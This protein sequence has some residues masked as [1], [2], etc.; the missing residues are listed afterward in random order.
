MKKKNLYI[1]KQKGILIAFEGVSG[2]G[3]SEGVESLYRYLLSRGYKTK[4]I[5]WN[6]NKVIRRIV[7]KIHSMKLLTSWLYSIFQWISFLLDYYLKITPLLKK[8]C[9]LIADRYIYTG[10]TRDIANEA[11]QMIA[12]KLHRVI[13]KPDL[14]FFYDVDLQVCY[15]RIEKRGKFLFYPNNR[16]QNNEV[17]KNKDLDYL[18]RLQQEYFHL[19]QSSTLTKETNIICLGGSYDLAEIKIRKHVEEYIR[20]KSGN[21]CFSDKTAISKLS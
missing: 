1:N 20:L 11:G 18:I 21:G 13:R 4:V 12:K 7:Q 17:L 8:D 3:K 19:F 9:I 10:H 6:S 2:C 5:E 14:I 15:E 16:I